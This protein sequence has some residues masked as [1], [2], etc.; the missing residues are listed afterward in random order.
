MRGGAFPAQESPQSEDK[1]TYSAVPLS[2]SLSVMNQQGGVSAV[3]S[4]E[5]GHNTSA[6]LESTSPHHD[7]SSSLRQMVAL[8]LAPQ[9][10]C[11]RACLPRLCGSGCSCDEAPLETPS[12]AGRDRHAVCEPLIRVTP[13]VY[14]GRSFVLEKSKLTPSDI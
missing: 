2:H 12:I 11:V 7:P 13:H 8:G 3:F 5:S 14:C 10:V 1:K 6:H 4:H 9:R